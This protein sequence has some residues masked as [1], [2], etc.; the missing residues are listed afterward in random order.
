MCGEFSIGLLHD[1]SLNRLLGA[2]LFQLVPVIYMPE[3]LYLQ[4]ERAPGAEN[5][6]TGLLLRIQT[7]YL[8]VVVLQCTDVER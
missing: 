7:E 8:I 2:D 1:P 4:G 6:S 5:I 3:Q